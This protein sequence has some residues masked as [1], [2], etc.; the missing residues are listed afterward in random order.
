VIEMHSEIALRYVGFHCFG[1]TD[2]ASSSD[3]VYFTFGV[4]PNLVELQG[5]YQ[6]RIISDVDAGESHSEMY[7]ME[8]Y[9]GLPLGAAVSITLVEHDEGDPDKYKAIVK[10]GVDK[11]ADEAQKAIASIPTVGVYLGFLAMLVLEVVKPALTDAINELI[12]TADDVIGTV[13]LALTPKDMLRLTRQ[14]PQDFFGIMAHVESPLISGQGGSYKAYFDVV[15][16]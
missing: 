5:T 10:K 1:E 8:I 15:I 12:G 6:T 7:P 9:S 3:E 16:P 11:G 4:V 2:E 14:G 13:P